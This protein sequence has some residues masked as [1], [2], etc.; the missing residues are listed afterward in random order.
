MNFSHLNEHTFRNNFDH[1]INTMH[2]CGKEPE[3][4]FH[5]LLRCDLHS[6]YRLEFR[7]DI[8]ALKHS[9]MKISEEILLTVLHYGAEES[10]FKINSEN[11]KW[12]IK[13]INKQIALVAHY[14]LLN[15]SFLP[16]DQVFGI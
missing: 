8:C 9:L 16:F 11:L 10:S 7:N 4:T 1:T 3:T 6:I 12:A 14:F 13:F 2:S 15:F 5:Y